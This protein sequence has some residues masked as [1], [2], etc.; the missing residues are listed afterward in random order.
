MT[1]TPT[2]PT[3]ARSTTVI[4]TVAVLLALW[5]GLAAPDVS[6]VAPTP[7]QVVPVVSQDDGVD[8]PFL[9]GL[10]GDGDRDGRGRR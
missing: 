6:P 4:S 8:L 5:L 10:F 9:G 3:R 7:T 2:S 1:D